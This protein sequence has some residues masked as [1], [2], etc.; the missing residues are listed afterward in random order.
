MNELEKSIN[1]NENLI[2]QILKKYKGIVNYSAF[3]YEDLFQEAVEGFI[4]AYK[5]YDKSKGEFSTYATT[6]IRNKIA[7]FIKCCNNQFKFPYVYTLVWKAMKEHETN[8]ANKLSEILNIPLKK[9]IEAMVWYESKEVKQF[10][11]IIDIENT[12]TLKSEDDTSIVYVN[13]FVNKFDG[14]NKQIIE[15]RLDD[16]T[17]TEISIELKIS[18]CKVSV[19]LGKIKNK[20]SIYIKQGE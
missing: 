11:S 8:D 1:E 10:G 18:Q 15:M 14:E 9:V 19:T 16:K 20:L 5:T 7:N 4:K 13:E 6:V 17:Q 12:N 3:D 2:H